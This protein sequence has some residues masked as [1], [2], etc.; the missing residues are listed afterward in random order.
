[1]K[2][3]F[4]IALMTQCLVIVSYVQCFPSWLVYH[5]PAFNGKV[6]D[7]ESKEP[8]KGAVIVVIY[9]SSPIISGPGGGSSSVTHVKETVTDENGIFRIPSYTTFIQ[10][11][12][13]G[14]TVDFI[15][16]KPGFISFPS[17][18][19]TPQYYVN[20]EVYFSKELGT[21]GEMHWQSGSKSKIIPVTFGIVELPKLETKEERL[22]AIPSFPFGSIDEDE[23]PLLYKAINEER[24][25]FGLGPIGRGK[26]MSR[27]HLIRLLTTQLIGFAFIVRSYALDT[28]TH[29]Q[30]NE[31]LVTR[32]MD[33][34]SLDSYLKDE[35]GIQQGV[36]YQL[37]G[38][39]DGKSKFGEVWRWFG[40][41]GPRE[42]YSWA[43]S[44]NHFH[45]PLTDQGFS[46]V[47]GTGFYSG[48]SSIVWSQKPLQTQTPGGYYSWNDV[49]DYY[50]NALTATDTAMK[51]RLFA[52]T[53]R[54]L[55]QL[56]HLV[57]DLS[58]PEHARDDGHYIG[59]LGLPVHYERWAREPNVHIDRREGVLS[60]AGVQI[61]P[62]FFDFSQ[63]SIPNPLASVPVANLFD[64]NQ[65]VLSNPTP[66]TTLEAGIGLSEYTNANF[67][68]PDTMFVG[69]FPS[70]CINDCVISV[71]SR[72][73][74][75]YLSSRGTGQQVDHLAAV[76]PLYSYRK[77]YFPG[78]DS[79]LPVGLDPYCYEEY[80]SHLIPRAVGY[81]ADLLKYFFRGEMGLRVLPVYSPIYNSVIGLR[82]WISNL[83]PTEEAMTDG[84]FSLVCSYK[85]AAGEDVFATSND[86]HVDE[87][88]YGNEHEI[89]HVFNFRE[90][91]S[92][93]L[94]NVA[95][96]KCT[97]AFRG[98]LGN[99]EGAVVGKSKYVPLAIFNEPW[100]N[101]L[102]GNYPWEHTLAST[103][104]DNGET[105]NEVVAG[106]LI[107]DNIRWQ[108]YPSGRCNES[109]FLFTDA[110]NPDGILITPNTLLQFKID[111]LSINAIPPA[112]PG[113]TAHWQGLWIR[114]N[115]GR[116]LQFSQ[117]GQFVYYNDTTV[118][119]T[120]DLGMH[121]EAGIQELFELEGIEIPEP[122][123]LE[124]IDLYQQLW[125]L[126]EPS[127]EVHH[128][129]MRVDYIRIV[130]P[131]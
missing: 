90:G 10:P 84:T 35:L 118:Y 61:V 3:A 62:R 49:R 21:K 16:Y 101:G 119:A 100:N 89:E 56:M 81:S 130:E 96:V 29:R 58:V 123:Y 40:E 93:L 115:Q 26:R 88:L 91:Q 15:I 64:T 45:N 14:D 38:V 110:Q 131:N 41:G 30:I 54:G 95:S 105:Y 73:N 116:Y 36:E 85:N 6:V 98:T 129:R 66:S 19:V 86:F 20:S 55:G 47:W 23:A 120:F 114:F 52:E 74:R 18:A 122:L 22:R 12:S 33:G 78:N 68:S 102:T 13:V 72:N 104:P 109:Y 127:T 32:T 5:K 50:Y 63:I 42:D 17:D 25:R 24:K 124:D 108:G 2:K 39:L 94:Y 97:L 57:Q 60:I 87:L 128:Q 107:K 80:A 75:Q 28:I 46:G 65:Y 69:V 67:L 117:E 83:T 4:I 59:G 53:F 1:M 82:V 126:T 111:E 70:P 9:Y 121:F 51:D 11:N 125:T 112:P 31:Y 43:R 92:I 113:T 44:A 79:Y 8:I 103:Q 106:R 7:A 48:D 99:E 27:K 34:F 37:Q 76:S 77:R 71:D